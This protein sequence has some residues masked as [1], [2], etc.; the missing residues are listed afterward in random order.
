M[1]IAISYRRVTLP[2]PIESVVDRQVHKINALLKSYAPDLVQL[3]GTLEANPHRPEFTFSVNLSLPTGMLH[4]S[5]VSPDA[6]TCARQALLE[7]EAQIKKHQ[8][9]LRKQFE[10]KGK[11][12]AVRGTV[13]GTLP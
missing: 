4:A 3:R 12:G 6:R 1:N 11:R 2:Q 10:W 7:L 13:R 5:A 8:A 9:L